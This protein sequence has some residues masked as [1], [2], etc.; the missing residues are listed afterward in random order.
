MCCCEGEIKSRRPLGN[1]LLTGDRLPLIKQVIHY[2]FE[3]CVT[4]P[5]SRREQGKTKI[6][7]QK[8]ANLCRTESRAVFVNKSLYYINN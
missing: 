5:K 3:I 4:M 8:R 1:A 2:A 7:K 6:P